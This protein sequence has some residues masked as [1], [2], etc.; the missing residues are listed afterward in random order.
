MNYPNRPNRQ[1][2]K[3]KEKITNL[4]NRGMDF[5]NAINSSNLH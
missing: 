2:T 1:E 3:S 4:A 5:E